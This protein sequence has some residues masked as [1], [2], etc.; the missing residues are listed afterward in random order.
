M[1]K[2]KPPLAANSTAKIPTPSTATPVL[3]RLPLL[4]FCLPSVTPGCW[5]P[6]LLAVLELGHLLGDLFFGGV[7]IVVHSLGSVNDSLE[8]SP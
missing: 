2:V 4:S 1:N 6:G 3:V 8:L 5:E 7:G